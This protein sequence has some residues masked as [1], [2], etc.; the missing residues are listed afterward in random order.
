MS[1]RSF[2]AQPT[3]SGMEEALNGA[4]L[5]AESE[6]R[7]ANHHLNLLIEATEERD[8]LRAQMDAMREAERRWRI[9]PESM[10]VVEMVEEPSPPTVSRA[11][12][13]PEGEG[14]QQPPPR[15]LPTEEELRAFPIRRPPIKGKVTILED[16]PINMVTETNERG[17]RAAA[18]LRN[19]VTAIAAA[20]RKTF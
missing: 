16:R 15:V 9:N 12:V 14:E 3:I 7:K 6:R 18:P 4:L 11:K 1:R 20:N 17:E 2:V 8:R 13:T 10:E 19:I 5:E